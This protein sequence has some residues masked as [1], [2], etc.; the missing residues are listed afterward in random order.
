M[1][2]IAVL[3][4]A[5]DDD[6]PATA[7]A[8]KKDKVPYD[9]TI[10][11]VDNEHS[12]IVVRASGGSTTVAMGPNSLAADVAIGAF[13]IEDLLV[14]PVCMENSYLA[15]S[16]LP[17]REKFH[18]PSLDIS[19]MHQAPSEDSAAS[20]EQFQDASDE[21]PQATSQ[22]QA[23]VLQ[24]AKW[25]PKSPEYQDVDAQVRVKL[26]TL[27]FFGNRP[28]LGALMAIGD[29][30]SIASAAKPPD[31]PAAA[32]HQRTAEGESS[33]HPATADLDK[34][35]GSVTQSVVLLTSSLLSVCVNMSEATH[36]CYA[37]KH[38]CCNL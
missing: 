33:E 9:Q 11:N 31:A 38:K 6:E 23:L 12:L 25:T 3:Q 7:A 17:A 2:Y 16:S 30:I 13:E 18:E 22:G 34:G 32:M 19:S 37:S 14:G 24:Y 36:A 21:L 35:A 8:P 29:D 1:T 5:E 26:K 28:T 4:F 20:D 10:V 15:R 27:S